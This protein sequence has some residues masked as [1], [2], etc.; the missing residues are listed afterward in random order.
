MEIVTM[1]M[2]GNNKDIPNKDIANKDIARILA[3]NGAGNNHKTL[4]KFVRNDCMEIVTMLM[5]GN[6][7]SDKIDKAELWKEVKSFS[8]NSVLR[9]KGLDLQDED[10]LVNLLCQVAIK[11]DVEELKEGLKLKIDVNKLNKDGETAL[12]CAVKFGHV[13]VTK[14]LVEAGANIHKVNKGGQTALDLAVGADD[15]ET[16][17]LFIEGK[18]EFDSVIKTKP[19]ISPQPPPPPPGKF[20]SVNINKARPPTTQVPPP[21]PPPPT[22]PQWPSPSPQGPPPPPPPGKF[23]NI[24]TYNYKYKAKLWKDVKSFG[25][26]TVLAL[27]SLDIKDENIGEERGV[28]WLCQDARKC[29]LEGVK[30]GL[31]KNVTKN[32]LNEKGSSF[33]HNVVNGEG[34][35]EA[36]I[37]IIEVL[38][39][40]DA[41]KLKN[42]EGKTALDLALLKNKVKVVEYILSR[43]NICE[44]LSNLSKSS[45]VIDVK[46]IYPDVWTR[47]MTSDTTIDKIKAAFEH[48]DVNELTTAFN[49]DDFGMK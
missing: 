30:E 14:A 18:S 7:D 32:A 40:A 46:T 29:N 34:D 49:V 31:K 20:E 26:N 22:P 27:K 37:A 41:I 25:M 42:N 19:S 16:A 3:Q 4:S 21:P 10:V 35:E 2:E 15:V 12:H 36:I 23:E 11:S 28:E 24:N 38:F 44:T 48:A 45:D 1:L 5:E 43:R 47:I 33:L 39:E 13:P 17:K 9:L 6:I 8:M